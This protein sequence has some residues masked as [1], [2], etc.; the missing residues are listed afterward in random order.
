[1]VKGK[2]GT[3]S[4]VTRGKRFLKTLERRT[5][6]RGGNTI[7]DRKISDPK[8]PY[9]ERRVPRSGVG[10][11]GGSSSSGTSRN[12]PDQLGYFDQLCRI[13][14]FLLRIR[15]PRAASKN[16]RHPYLRK[17]VNP[18]GSTVRLADRE[19]K[20]KRL[21]GREKEKSH[22]CNRDDKEGD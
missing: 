4:E 20:R 11:G 5:A 18:N 8:R 3:R 19:Q 17:R 10:G 16:H 12:E 13:R 2:A 9:D 21:Q 22:G 14:L 6:Q 1:M 7:N 15:Q